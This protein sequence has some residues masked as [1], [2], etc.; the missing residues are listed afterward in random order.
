METKRITRVAVL[1]SLGMLLAGCLSPMPAPPSGPSELPSREKAQMFVAAVDVVQPLAEH[2]C[3][4][5]TRGVKCGF[6]VA[7]NDTP[8]I[9]PNAFQF[10]SDDGDPVI[11]FTTSI[12]NSMRNQDEVAFLFGH[13]AAHHI[14]G[15][16]EQEARQA[17]LGAELLGRHASVNGQDLAGIREA[18]QLGAAIGARRYSKTFELEADRLGAIIAGNAGY[19]PVLGAAF[20]QRQPDPGN[21]FLGTHPPNAQRIAV[22]RDVVA[23]L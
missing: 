13:E 8:G 18:Q 1:L 10:V 14:L 6:I 22:V 3:R 21:E 9:Q 2:E 7:I 11:V 17:R 12:I 16:I 15:H 20:F 23:G 5:R 4:R 19:D